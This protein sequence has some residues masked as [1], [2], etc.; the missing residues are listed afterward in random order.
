MLSAP[1]RPLPSGTAT[2]LAGLHGE[3]LEASLLS[4]F[5]PRVLARYYQFAVE[6]EREIVVVAE[7]AGRVTGAAVI[8]LEPDRL[9]RRFL[10]AHLISALAGLT[11]TLLRHPGRLGQVIGFLRSDS[12]PPPE[13][14]NLPEVLQLF[15]AAEH[16]GKGVGRSLL[17]HAEGLLRA[18]GFTAYFVKTR[19]AEGNPALG[20]YHALD[21]Q[22]VGTHAFKGV[23]YAYLRKPL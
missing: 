14:D 6:S 11:A 1:E 10:R 18:A 16:R 17:V 7:T 2:Q 22:L 19:Q 15:T 21:F 12:R 23:E 4:L 13:V 8:S 20:F 3:A 9:A 5:G